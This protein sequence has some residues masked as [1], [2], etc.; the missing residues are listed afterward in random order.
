M[1]ASFRSTARAPLTPK[2]SAVTASPLRLLPMTIL[3][4]RSFMSLR[5]VVRAKMAINSLPTE[6]SNCVCGGLK[7][8]TYLHHPLP[9]LY[10]I[11]PYLPPF[12]PF[13]LP[14]SFPP[15]LLP[16][17]PLSLLFPSFQTYLPRMSFL[18]WRLPHSDLSQVAIISVNHSV[19]RYGVRIN[20]KSRE[21][22]DLV[23]CEVTR[24]A[25]V[26]SKLL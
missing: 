15:S 25:L 13:I 1:M 19:P 21:P 22:S 3:P 14:P 24:V 26:D 4:S 12:P 23:P 10:F 5:L 9:S 16:S 20:I 11:P 7:K 6:I 8:H 18:S 17:L 2:S